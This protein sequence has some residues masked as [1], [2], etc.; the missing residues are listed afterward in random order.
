MNCNLQVERIDS[1]EK[2]PC[3]HARGCTDLHP[4]SDTQRTWPSKRAKIVAASLAAAAIKRFR[5]VKHVRTGICGF[6]PWLQPCHP[7]T[8]GSM[9]G[10]RH[11]PCYCSD[12]VRDGCHARDCPLLKMLDSRTSKRPSLLTFLNPLRAS[13]M[14]FWSVY[15]RMGHPWDFEHIFLLIYTLGLLPILPR[16]RSK[17]RPHIHKLLFEKCSSSIVS[18]PRRTLFMLV[19]Q[20]TRRSKPKSRSI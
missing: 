19:R 7:E 9:L 18:P 5:R 8:H 14:P 6:D 17:V 4:P 15:F 3:C 12:F 16:H 2:Y 10:D 13:L 20:M 1:L 11:S